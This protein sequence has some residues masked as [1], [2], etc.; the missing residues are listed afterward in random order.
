[1]SSEEAWMRR[2]QS[3]QA[4]ENMT[5]QLA[6]AL[7]GVPYKYFG[8]WTDRIAVGEIPDSKPP[9]PQGIER[10]IVATVRDWS[11]PKHYLHD[12]TTTDRRKPT[13]NA[14]GPIVGSP[15]L[16]T[17]DMPILDVVNNKATMF[18]MPVRD[19][20]TP[21]TNRV[22]PAA[23]SPYWGEERIWDSKANHHNAMFDD[24][25]RVWLA[26]AVRAPDN[27]DYCK[28]GSDLSSAKLTPTEKTNRHIAMYD[29][30]PQQ[31]KSVATCA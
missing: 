29:P 12:L 21:T 24:K 14:Y 15:E 22:P 1:K 17:D 30:N 25:G 26:A 4:G 28:K 7:S 9:R 6:G 3:G 13:V 19:A 31:H 8:D 20:N 27:P 11:D 23:P 10:N 5:N 16:S 18:H 2:I